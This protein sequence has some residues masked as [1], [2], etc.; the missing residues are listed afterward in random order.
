MFERLFLPVALPLH[1]WFPWG[2]LFLERYYLA[3]ERWQADNTVRKLNSSLVILA[4]SKGTQKECVLR[5]TL[6][7]TSNFAG[8]S[9]QTHLYSVLNWHIS[10]P[11]NVMHSM[12][13]LPWAEGSRK[14]WLQR[15]R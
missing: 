5:L 3:H 15:L 11:M 1:Q 13:T 7:G 6:P 4:V 9:A 8:R 12:Q 2:A 14:D 10:K